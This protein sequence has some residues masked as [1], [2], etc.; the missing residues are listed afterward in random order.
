MPIA[1]A[2]CVDG[3]PVAIASLHHAA[4]RG[5]VRTFQTIKLFGDMTVLEHVIIGF[6]RHSGIGRGFGWLAPRRSH[7]EAAH[8]LAAARDLDRAGRFVTLRE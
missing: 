4:R 7:E 8:N 3:E 6:A 5:I 2:S 1:A